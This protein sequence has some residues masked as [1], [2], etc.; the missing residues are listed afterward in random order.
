MV[1]D[2]NSRS[3]E[4]YPAGKD[5]PTLKLNNR[6]SRWE[7]VLSFIYEAVFLANLIF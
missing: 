3:F 4:L 1:F 6:S 2:S 7:I 5:S